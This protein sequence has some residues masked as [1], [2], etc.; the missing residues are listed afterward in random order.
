VTACPSKDRRSSVHL[1]GTRSECHHRWCFASLSRWAPP[2]REI[3]PRLA[4]LPHSPQLLKAAWPHRRRRWPLQRLRRRAPPPSEPAPHWR[5]ASVSPCRHDL[6][7]RV[8][9]ISPVPAPPVSLHLI[10][11]PTAGS[12]VGPDPCCH[13]LARRVGYTSPVPA[14]LV[15]LHLITSP[16]VGSRVGPEHGDCACRPARPPGRCGFWA[17]PAVPDLGPK[18]GPLRCPHFPISFLI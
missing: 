18:A 2:S 3:D 16:V 1:I 15:P 12:R 5:T 13:D 7:R 14:P 10:A 6:A 11:S 17:R 8:G 4:G 9:C